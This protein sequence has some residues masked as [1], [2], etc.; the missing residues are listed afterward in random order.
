MNEYLDKNT[1]R[2]YCLCCLYD[3]IDKIKFG[4]EW[5]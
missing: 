2:A 5:L 1:D 3:K 4:G